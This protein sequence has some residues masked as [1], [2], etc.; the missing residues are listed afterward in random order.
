MR[1]LIYC[2]VSRK[3]QVE[4]GVSLEAQEARCREFCKLHNLEVTQVITDPG[5]SAKSLK[6]PGLKIALDLLR[7]K[8]VDGCV[9]TK[10]DRLTRSVMDWQLLLRDYFGAKQGRKLY[11]VDDHIAVRTA[12]DR[13]LLNIRIA[14][15]QGEREVIGERTR[16]SLSYKRKNGQRV[17]AVPFG[18]DLDPTNP[19]GL[20][21]NEAEQA[22]LARIREL[23]GGGRSYRAIADELTRVGIKSKNG[24]AWSAMVVSR[25]CKRSA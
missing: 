11:A 21:P 15:S 3:E 10:L 7:K 19:K 9:V 23:R 14:I 1:V 6:R 22:T 25:I 2:R 8:Q 18:F 20:I 16:D 17:G 5:V 12:M 13:M 24:G 4:R